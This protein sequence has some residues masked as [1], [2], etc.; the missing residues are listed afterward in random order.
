MGLMFWPG[1]LAGFTGAARATAEAKE[2]RLIP[3]LLEKFSCGLGPSIARSFARSSFWLRVVSF[4]PRGS[5]PLL[6][7]HI[8]HLRSCAAS[9]RRLPLSDLPRV[10]T[11]DKS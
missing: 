5:R 4:E 3:E 7:F 2:C 11:G 8:C 6:F 10:A 1:K 9:C